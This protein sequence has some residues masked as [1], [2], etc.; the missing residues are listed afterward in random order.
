LAQAKAKYN[1]SISASKKALISTIA[2]R[3]NIAADAGD[4][5]TVVSLRAVMNSAE[6]DGSIPSETTDPSILEAKAR[7][8]RSIQTSRLQLAAAY[9]QAIRDL[10]KARQ[11][12]QA[13]NIQSEFDANPELNQPASTPLDTANPE[14]GIELLGTMKGS[15]GKTES[16]VIVLHEGDRI[17]TSAAF[18]VPVTFRI[19][20]MTDGT[21]IRIAYAADQM[22]FNWRPNETQLRIDGGPAGGR[23]LNGAGNIP[24]NQWVEL[25]LEVLPDSLTIRVDGRQRYRTAADF[26][27]VNQSLSI[28]QGE[29]STV[30]VKSVLVIKRKDAE[31]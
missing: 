8:D 2:A 13:E 14:Q 21:D 19:T 10:T 25:T 31:R 3:I 11:F 23:Y 20:A 5:K 29:G 17:D 9:K 30:R 6:A 26:S 27:H 16:G 28:F 1:E 24:K 4:L 7:Y 12:E 18:A 15:T 22:I